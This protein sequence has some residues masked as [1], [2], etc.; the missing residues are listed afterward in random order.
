ML[1]LL[2]G[3]NCYCWRCQLILRTDA[4]LH[5]QSLNCFGAEALCFISPKTIFSTLIKFHFQTPVTHSIKTLLPP[6]HSMVSWNRHW[7]RTD[8]ASSYTS[9]HFSLRPQVAQ[10]FT[11]GHLLF[12]E[13]SSQQ[14]Q[15]HPFEIMS[16][17][18]SAPPEKTILLSQ[19]TATLK[20]LSP[21][22]WPI[23]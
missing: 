1:C 20:L 2:H 19:V 6:F 17:T 23:F 21:Q 12:R 18:N 10:H 11:R 4:V 9:L 3:K 7:V 16:S 5:I 13:V 22:P 8:T 15:S 14:I